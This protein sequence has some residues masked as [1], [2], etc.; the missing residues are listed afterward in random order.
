[1]VNL[2]AIPILVLAM[3]VHESE[4]AINL[5]NKY[6]SKL[7]HDLYVI[8]GYSIFVKFIIRDRV[9]KITRLHSMCIEAKTFMHTEKGEKAMQ[10]LGYIQGA[11][12][13]MNYDQINLDF[14]GVYYG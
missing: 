10:W 6:Q 11:M 9:K 7:S 12:S 14:E 13:M 1:M 3:G 5:L 8:D 4:V 2:K